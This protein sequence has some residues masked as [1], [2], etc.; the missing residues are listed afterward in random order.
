MVKA[1]ITCIGQF[2]MLQALFEATIPGCEHYHHLH[3]T[4]EEIKAQEG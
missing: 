1:M 3:F 2:A 4:E